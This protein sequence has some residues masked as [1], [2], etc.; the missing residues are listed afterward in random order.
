VTPHRAS[1]ADGNRGT[2]IIDRRTRVGRIAVAS[3][4]TH[5]PT[6]RRLNEMITTL[7]ETG[8]DDILRALRDGEISPLSVYAAFRVNEL[9]RLPLGKELLPLKDAMTKWNE[10]NEAGKQRRAANKSG[11]KRL[12][13]KASIVGN[14]PDA[15]L[16]VRV[17]LIKEGHPA[18]F[19]RIR[20]TALA[21]IRDTLKRSH[22]LYG[23]VMD[24][25]L[26]KEKKAPR[27]QPQTWAQ[28]AAH[29]ET[30]NKENPR[31]RV[32]LWAMALCG[33]GPKEYFVDGFL[34]LADR[35]KVGGQKRRGRIRDVPAVRTEYFTRKVP[36]ATVGAEREM[37]VFGEKLLEKCGIHP[38]DLRR[39]YANWME[40]AGIPRTR[41]RLYIG[42]ARKDTTDIYEEHEVTAFLADDARRLEA[43]LATA[44]ITT[45]IT[46]VV[47]ETE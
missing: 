24:V 10:S 44:P 42:H 29:A 26:L 30:M 12:A 37:R 32:A 21:F 17:D 40:A 2:F 6:F 34:V 33:M 9:H 41:R 35:V 38:Y 4:T 3:G 36:S 16:Q 47:G 15:L 14:L 31:F 23:E 25:P 39:T 19:N 8:R 28:L 43:Y 5:A 13:E 45:P 7:N 22:H 18:H 1:F 46:P 11:I 27:R 20:A